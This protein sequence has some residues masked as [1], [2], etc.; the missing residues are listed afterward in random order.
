[1]TVMKDSMIGDEW[2]KQACA[3]NPVSRVIDPKTGQ[4]NGNLLSGPVRLAFMETLFE[5]RAPSNGSG[6]AKFGCMAI[7]T[8][9]TDLSIY[10]EEYYKVLA[11]NF[12]DYYVPGQSVAGQQTAGYYAGLQVPFHDQAEK[13]KFGGFTP[14]LTYINHN[15][16]YM[17]QIVDPRGNPI[18]DRNKIYA[19]VWAILAVNAYPYGKNPPQPKKGCAFGLQQV[20]IIGDDTKLAGGAPDP[21]VTFAGVN[22][23]PPQVSP[24]ASFG[25]APPPA[26]APPPTQSLYPPQGFAPPPGLGALRPPAP[27]P[28]DDTD[29]SQ[30]M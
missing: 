15:S 6:K 26:G 2:I 12:P 9:F 29:V 20:M 7:Y 18:T 1:M 3:L 8:P 19:G 10:Y 25:N 28:A 21:R 24:A 11:A 22:V 16:N 4:P 27:A 23:K 14:G 13:I 5:A 30:Y 17:P